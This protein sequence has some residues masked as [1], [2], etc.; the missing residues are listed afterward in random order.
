MTL[1]ARMRGGLRIALYHHVSDRTSPL[2]DGLNVRTPPALFEAHVRRLALDYEIVDL[3]TVLAGRL[4][5]RALLITFDDGYRSVV[6]VA[7]PM[8]ERLG[9]PSVFFVSDAFLDPR[10][11]PLDNVLCRLAATEGV[12]ALAAAVGAREDA[13]GLAEVFARVAALPYGR[14]MT[15]VGRLADRFEIDPAALRASS[16]LFLERGELRGLARRGCEVGNHTASHLSC[17]AIVDDAA[18]HEQLVAHR[19]MLERWTGAP[20]RSF[21]YPYGSRPDATP[22]VERALRASGH[23]LSFLVEARPNRPSHTG[24]TYNRVS[25]DARSLW[26]VRAELELLPAMRAARDRVRNPVVVGG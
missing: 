3:Q 20:V 17:R 7:L 19:E 26:R 11:L 22:L 10:S 16:G 6:D 8:L 18:A 2:E 25:L 24:P 15:L 14:R 1:L 4:P 9:L 5:R 21:S 12:P 23:E 13:A